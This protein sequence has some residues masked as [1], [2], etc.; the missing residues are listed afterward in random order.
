MASGGTF[1]RQG[2]LLTTMQGTRHLNHRNCITAVQPPIISDAFLLQRR[3]ALPQQ[4]SGRHLATPQR[5]PVHMLASCSYIATV[6]AQQGAATP[7]LGW[8]QVWGSAAAQAP[9]SP[10]RIH[11][12]AR[13]QGS[14]V[15]WLGAASL[16]RLA[17]AFNWQISPEGRR[18]TRD[19]AQAERGG[20]RR[21]T[22]SKSKRLWCIF[23]TPSASQ[24]VAMKIHVTASHLPVAIAGQAGPI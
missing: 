12:A 9:P 11:S 8:A 13:S 3:R 17:G 10:A 18:P 6:T 7:A 4:R 20:A 2:P 22:H 23:V 16:S 5:T 1:G 15:H 21:C 19:K 14:A 24:S